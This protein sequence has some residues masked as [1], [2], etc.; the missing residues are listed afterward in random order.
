M[1]LCFNPRTRKGCDSVFIFCILDNISFNPRTRKGCDIHA[2]RYHSEKSGFNP[3]TRK[4]CDALAKLNESQIEV[5][6]HAP[7]KD[8][9]FLCLYIQ[10]Y[11]RFQSTHP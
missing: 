7:V 11:I 8:A 6:I 1:D 3:R 2:G 5:S 9:T 10:K 4:G